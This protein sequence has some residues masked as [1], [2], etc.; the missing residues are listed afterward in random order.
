MSKKPKKPHLLRVAAEEQLAF[1]KQI[2]TPTRSS[3]DLLHELQVHQVEL[4]MQNEELLR[5]YT[6]LEESHNRYVNL[7]EFAPVGYLTLEHILGFKVLAEGVETPE[8]LAFLREK[9]CDSYQ[10]FL[11]SRPIPAEDFA[12]LLLNQQR[13]GAET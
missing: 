5:A 9:G 2:D 13:D 10:G 12:K 7:Y 3:D 8:Q 4:A 11:K 1:T 6:A